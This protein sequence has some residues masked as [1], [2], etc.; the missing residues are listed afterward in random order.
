MNTCNRKQYFK[1]KLS[2]PFCLN[3]RCVTNKRG[4]TD[5]SGER[6]KKAIDSVQFAKCKI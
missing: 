5:I 6:I 3:N 1:Y 4:S 2:N